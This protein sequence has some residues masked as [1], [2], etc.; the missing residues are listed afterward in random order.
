[1]V[2]VR[3]QQFRR[4]YIDMCLWV[5][6]CLVRSKCSRRALDEIATTQ[7]STLGVVLPVLPGRAGEHLSI[8]RRANS[9]VHILLYI[10]VCQCVCVREPLDYAM[11][12]SLRGINRSSE[13]VLDRNAI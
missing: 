4:E 9:P 2:I 8:R 5:V 13:P 10:F 3:Y 12:A 7:E 6:L 1:M 11:Y